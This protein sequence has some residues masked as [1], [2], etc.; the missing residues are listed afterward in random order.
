MYLEHF[1]KYS[2]ESERGELQRSQG[3]HP[4]P[5]KST[6]NITCKQTGQHL[7]NSRRQSNQFLP[8]G[9]ARKLR[10]AKT[11]SFFRPPPPCHKYYT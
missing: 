11:I 9:V 7:K 1:F 4:T 3:Y 8:L 5:V 2:F 10:Q 6:S